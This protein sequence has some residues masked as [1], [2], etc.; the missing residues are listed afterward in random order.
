ML[1]LFAHAYKIAL[2]LFFV[3]NVI[4]SI[5][6]FLTMLAHT[7]AQRQLLI[8][9]REMVIALAILLSFYYFGKDILETLDISEAVMSMAGGVLLF[10]IALGMVFPKKEQIHLHHE[11]PLIVPLATPGIAGPGAISTVMIYAGLD[12]VKGSLVVPVAILMAWLPSLLIL[13]TA[14]QLRRFLG[15]KTLIALERLGGMIM[16]LISIQMLARGTIA[17]VK[18]SFNL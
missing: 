18:T 15:E 3:L 5:P 2:P 11:E 9:A 8:V 10:I 6:L 16:T 1:D 4:G 12:P 13:L 17:L 7:S 14:S